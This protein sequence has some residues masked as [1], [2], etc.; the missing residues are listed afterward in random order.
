MLQTVDCIFALLDDLALIFIQLC[1][2]SFM[3]LLLISKTQNH[4]KSIL[5][6]KYDEYS[7][8]GRNQ[9]DWPNKQTRITES[10]V[11]PQLTH[12]LSYL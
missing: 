10:S 3:N 4:F 5:K 6:V 1:F 9:S 2:M 7:L 11:F 12:E 8:T